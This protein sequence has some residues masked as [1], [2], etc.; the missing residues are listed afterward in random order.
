MRPLYVYVD[1]S[2]Q[3]PLSEVFVVVAVV[4]ADDQT[5]LRNAL[6]AIESEARTHGLK[7]RKTKNDRR[8][9]YLSL[10][11]RRHIAAGKIYLGRYR[12][13]VPH[14]YPV[15]DVIERAVARTAQG[16]RGTARV[17]VD[18]LNKKS[19]VN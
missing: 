8:T 5:S 14:F 11:L 18:G 9:R 13:P 2:G 15:L 17:Y 3:D 4:S 19:R 1:E 6:L 16:G 7:W 12:K 10:A